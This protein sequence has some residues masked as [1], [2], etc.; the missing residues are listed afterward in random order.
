MKQR[1]SSSLFALAALAMLLAAGCA[2]GPDFRSPPLPGAEIAPQEPAPT[3]DASR[4]PEWWIALGAPALDATV[5]TALA[6]NRELALAA[7][8][9]EEAQANVA[10]E[11][12]RLGPE[13]DLGASVGRQKYGF[14]FLGPQHVPAFHYF[15]V[16][17]TATL[18]LDYLGGERRAVERE[19]AYAEFRV[20]QRD[21]AYLAVTGN[22]V[23]QAIA[24][25]SA[26]EQLGYAGDIVDGDRRAVE[27]AQLASDAGAGT[28]VELVAAQRQLHVDRTLLPS[29]QQDQARAAHALAM[30]VGRSPEDWSPPPLTLADLRLPEVAASLPS[31]LVRTRPD[32]LAAES[33]LH[34]ATAAV[35]VA[36]AD[37][38]PQI[39]LSAS[40]GPQAPSVAELFDHRRLA[41]TLIAGLAAPLFDGGRLRAR[42]DAAAAALR[43]CLAQYDQ[44]VL[45]SFA[46]VADLLAALENDAALIEA[47]LAAGEAIVA[48]VQLARQDH[49]AGNAG[50]LPVLAAERNWSLA[51]IAHTR[52]RTQ[53]HEDLVRLML[54]LGG[55]LPSQAPVAEDLA[56]KP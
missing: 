29:L 31:E 39:R 2:V 23:L 56:A 55:G 25:A 28:R 13:V 46:E 12:G 26:Q 33:Q 16:T 42:R 17:A 14:Q 34:A 30:L 11:T 4:Q 24:L 10:A 3:E 5:R 1:S 47:Q 8:R 7:A 32:I 21:A 22:V 43:G 27:L 45:Q 35:G 6:G 19:R 20:H 51:K 37:L 49:A 44:T 50:V 40:F 53:R 48:D 54:A 18:L 36:T 41:S 15:S 52:A 38:Y 9:F